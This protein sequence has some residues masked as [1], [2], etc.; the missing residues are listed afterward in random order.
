MTKCPNLLIQLSSLSET[1]RDWSQYSAGPFSVLW[2]TIFISTLL[3]NFAAN[4]I[5]SR[6]A[7]QITG[8]CKLM[9]PITTCIP[10][11]NLSQF[12]LHRHIHIYNKCHFYLSSRSL[13]GSNMLL[14]DTF[15]SLLFQDSI[16]CYMFRPDGFSIM[17]TTLAVPSAMKDTSRASDCFNAYRWKGPGL[18][19]LVLTSAST[20]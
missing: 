1:A 20:I 16:N 10:T 18:L 9:F 4:E 6:L 13:L 2:P 5:S 3:V 12:N 15:F 8:Q 7:S 11:K 14:H 17:M 19:M